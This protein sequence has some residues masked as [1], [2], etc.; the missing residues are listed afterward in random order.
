MRETTL[1]DFDMVVSEL[2]ALGFPREKALYAARERYPDVAQRTDGERATRENRWEKEEQ[3][4]CVKIF[5]AH[6]C[7]VYS[8]SQPRATKQSAGF[9]DL[10][11]FAP[12]VQRAWWFEVKRAVGGVQSAAQREFQALCRVCGIPY[13]IGGVAEAW[14]LARYECQYTAYVSQDS[15]DASVTPPPPTPQ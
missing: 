10:F 11:V 13:Y 3:A 2:V 6:G 4:E 12:R 15:A 7:V 5:R 14:G 8:L 9:A 1:S